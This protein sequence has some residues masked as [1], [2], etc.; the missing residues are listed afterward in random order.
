M[1]GASLTE[2]FRNEAALAQKFEE[3]R[4]DH[5]RQV[6]ALERRKD[7]LID[8]IENKV[9][10]RP[11]ECDLEWDFARSVVKYIRPDTGEEAG[12]RPMDRDELRI[13]SEQL[14]RERNPTLF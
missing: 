7:E 1:K 14:E 5:K 13:R 9:E 6:I 8:Q 10:F 2:C 11:L 3:F 4:K 12:S